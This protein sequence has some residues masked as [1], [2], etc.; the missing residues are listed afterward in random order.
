MK[1]I[2][3]LQPITI[4]T[5]QPTFWEMI[6]DKVKAM[7]TYQDDRDDYDKR[8]KEAFPNHAYLCPGLDTDYPRL[9]RYGGK[10]TLA[11]GLHFAAIAVVTFRP[12]KTDGAA[13]QIATTIYCERTNG[14]K[15]LRHL[16]FSQLAT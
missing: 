3:I 5:Q 6:P 1:D 16:S 11:H 2:P 4:Q 15:S 7:D 8:L 14:E 13:I 9:K 10:R 12:R